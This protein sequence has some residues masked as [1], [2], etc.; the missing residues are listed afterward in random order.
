MSSR[1][2][3]ARAR[4]F[5]PALRVTVRA[6]KAVVRLGPLGIL[7]W[8]AKDPRQGWD[9]LKAALRG[10]SRADWQYQRWL[11]RHPMNDTRRDEIRRDVERFPFQPVVSVVMPVYD[12]DEPWL[13]MAIESLIAQLYPR[14]ELCLVDDA[15]TRP[16]VRPLL[17]GFAAR[18][19]RI[20]L[21]LLEANEGISGA[22]NHG[23]A[24]ATGEF[25]GFVDHDDALTEDALYEVVKRLNADPA[26]DFLYTD[27]D[28]TDTCGRRVFPFFK[29]DWSPDLF[30]SMNY[31]THFAVFRRSLVEAV[32]ALRKGFEGSQ[33]YDL[34][35]RVAERTSRIAHVALPLYSWGEAPTSVVADP[36]AKLYAHEAGRRALQESLARRGIAGEILDG[37]GAP[38]R[39][40][41]KRTI[42]GRPLV[43]L[44]IPTRD[45]WRLLD[46]CLTS[47]EQRTAYRPLEVLVVDNQSPE[48]EAVRYL[49]A[50]EGRFGGIG[51]RVV[52]FA[53]P[54][55]F[56][57]MNNRAVHQTRGEYVL[58]L[59]DDTEAIELEWVSA[60]LEHA[61]RPEVGAVGAKLLFPNDRVQHAGVIVGIQGKAAHAFWG[62]PHDHPGYWDFARVVRN[63]SAV[64]G[65][66][67]MIR[68]SLFEE[69]GGFDEAFAIAYNDIDLCLRL[70]ERGYLVVYTPYAVLYHHQ[71]ASRGPYNPKKDRKPEALL[72]SRWGKVLDNDPYYSPHLTRQHCDFSLRT[73]ELAP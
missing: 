2:P 33:D 49:A 10:Y 39:Y 21:R 55:H 24:L 57:R 14:W 13:T 1:R 67:L 72:R 60:M 62:F 19:A 59:N 46:K 34:I 28:I 44:V 27:H 37:L 53:E 35:L 66:C 38:Y 58:L 36:A 5:E 6:S 32:G 73:D 50:V 18:D 42:L 31:V 26:T 47:L 65:A 22:S 68:K 3:G 45:N 40:R 41:V 69:V 16:H 61:Q 56:A 4:V 30:D 51:A 63:Y 8:V 71:S 25:V 9:A 15:S 29:P 23:L 17:E 70:R 20:R 54:F 52:P 48:P 12:A 11:A 43:S 7:R 64:T